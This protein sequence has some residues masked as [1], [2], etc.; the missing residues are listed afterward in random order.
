[1]SS[2]AAVTID[3]SVLKDRE[4]YNVAR[5]MA[6][7][8]ISYTFPDGFKRVD[9]M[10]K[11]RALRN[12][13]D[14]DV[15]YSLTAKMLKGKAVVITMTNIDGGTREFCRINAEDWGNLRGI[16]IVSD[17]PFLLVW[18]TEVVADS[19]AKELT[20]AWEASAAIV[21]DGKETGPSADPFNT[22]KKE[23]GGENNFLVKTC[24]GDELL[25]TCY[26]FYDRFKNKPNDWSELFDFLRFMRVKGTQREL[27]LEMAKAGDENV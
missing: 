27:A 7:D 24:F 1:M 3:A 4:V 22:E 25:Y 11:C 17:Y 6:K 20:D 8:T 16:K 2:S 19:L 12:L 26:E 10:T 21:G 13:D 23:G 9:L 18:L 14:F 15:V 5:G